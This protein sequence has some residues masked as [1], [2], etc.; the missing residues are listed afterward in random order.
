MRLHQLIE[1]EKHKLS[2][3]RI[4]VWI[5]LALAVSTVVLDVYAAILTGNGAIPNAVYSI[6]TTMFM[7]FASWAAGPRIAAHIGPQIGSAAQAV[8]NATRDARLPSKHDDERG[9]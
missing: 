1:D 3:A 5:T 7:V 6:E 4:G 9:V 2:V 8:A